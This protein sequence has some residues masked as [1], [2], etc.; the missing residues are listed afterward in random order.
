MIKRLHSALFLVD[1]ISVANEFY[2]KLGFNTIQAKEAVRIKF[3]DY[4][5]A[6]MEGSKDPDVPDPE[7]NGNGVF[8]YFEVED[9]KRFIRNAKKRGVNIKNKPIKQPWGKKELTVVDPDGYKL[10]FFEVIE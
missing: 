3:G 1:D 8:S 9:M 6:F 5:F 2:E 10:V 4:R 7:I